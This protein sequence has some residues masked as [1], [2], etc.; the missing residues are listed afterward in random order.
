[1]TILSKEI[2]QEITELVKIIN[3]ETQNKVTKDEIKE[4]INSILPDIDELISVKV[5]QHFIEIAE[6]IKNK[7]QS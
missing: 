1:M 3:E 2:E 5:K 6:F 7:F 4:V